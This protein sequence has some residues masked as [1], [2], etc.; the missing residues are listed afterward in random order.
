VESL[1]RLPPMEERLDLMPV[2]ADVAVDI[3]LVLCDWLQALLGVPKSPLLGYRIE[4]SVDLRG[5]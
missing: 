2:L 1:H 3:R 5:F 4:C